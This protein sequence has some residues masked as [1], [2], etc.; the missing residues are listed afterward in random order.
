MVGESPPPPRSPSCSWPRPLDDAASLPGVRRRVPVHST[1][2]I[3]AASMTRH[4]TLGHAHVDPAT[5][6]TTLDDR[7]PFTFPPA[8]TV[9]GRLCFLRSTATR[10]ALIP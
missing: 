5:G 8:D 9:P 7:L 3:T 1:R 4:G 2:H 6:H 10:R